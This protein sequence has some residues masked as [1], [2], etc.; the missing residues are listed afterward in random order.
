MIALNLKGN[1]SK[2]IEKTYHLSLACSKLKAAHPVNYFPG[3]LGEDVKNCPPIKLFL[4]ASLSGYLAFQ[5]I[6]TNLGKHFTRV[7]FTST[8]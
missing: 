1:I 5:I 4:F 2:F 3:F 7:K 8:Q 6:W